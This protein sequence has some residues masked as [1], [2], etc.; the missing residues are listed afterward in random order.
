MTVKEFKDKFKGNIKY[1]DINGID[2]SNK[3]EIILNL[4]KVIGSEHCPDG[5]I[6]VD[7]AYE[8]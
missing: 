5:T 4:I 7:V 3:P 1:Y 8:E 2:I 6:K